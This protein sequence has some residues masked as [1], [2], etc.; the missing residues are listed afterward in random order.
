MRYSPALDH[1][2]LAMAAM[3]SGKPAKLVAGH[4]AKALKSG[5]LDY[6]ISVLETSNS[7]AYSKLEAA[8][9]EKLEAAKKEK[10]AKPV[11]QAAKRLKA[12]AEVVVEE[13]D[14]TLENAQEPTQDIDYGE[15]LV[16][17][18]TVETA[19]LEVEDDAVVVEDDLDTDEVEVLE[20]AVGGD[21]LSDELSNILESMRKAGK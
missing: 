2:A 9:A 7:Q 20:D 3:R 21:D 6:A 13:S 8:K 5:D 18:L 15:D 17:D 4:L 1:M 11:T 14:T 10:D 12:E 16:N 19:E